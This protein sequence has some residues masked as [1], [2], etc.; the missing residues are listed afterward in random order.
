MKVSFAGSFPLAPA[1]RPAC[2]LL[3]PLLLLLLRVRPAAP[4]RVERGGAGRLGPDGSPGARALG[5][6]NLATASV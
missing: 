4:A 1:D 2:R 5:D 3:L 6:G